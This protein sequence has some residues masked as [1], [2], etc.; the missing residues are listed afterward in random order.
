MKSF[1]K[2]LPLDLTFVTDDDAALVLGAWF[3]GSRHG[4]AEWRISGAANRLSQRYSFVGTRTYPRPDHPVLE[5]RRPLIFTLVGILVSLRTTLE[6]EERA[7]SA[8]LRK[9]PTHDAL[10]LAS[11]EDLAEVLRP[12]GLAEMRAN[13]IRRALEYV[14]LE[15]GGALE[16]LIP[17]STIE[18]REKILRIPGFGPKSTDCLLSIGLGKP[19][20]A[21]DVNV[22]RVASR[23][24]ELP[25]SD[26][27]DFGNAD[28]V[29]AVKE[30]LDAALPQD[31]FVCQIVHTLFL[32]HG[33]ALGRRHPNDV[34]VCGL[35]PYC[36][37][38]EGGDIG[39][40]T[41]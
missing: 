39:G 20:I 10:R 18:A 7:M 5:K 32:L 8:L 19:S 14:D 16:N 41:C 37:S 6:N 34:S 30:A 40:P 22:F 36:R 15:F 33:K 35:S 28:Q 13:R 17:L 11:T 27:P 29:R 31:A 1:S 3:K 21:V 25:W 12:A 23:L 26:S 2:P 38:C 9:Y 24:L 4:T